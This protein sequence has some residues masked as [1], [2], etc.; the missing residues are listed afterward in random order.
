MPA[1]LAFKW[2]NL[3]FLGDYSLLGI[4]FTNP[5]ISQKSWLS[6]NSLVLLIFFLWLSV[7]AMVNVSFDDLQLI[8]DDEK[9]FAAVLGCVRCAAPTVDV[10]P[11][12]VVLVEDIPVETNVDSPHLIQVELHWGKK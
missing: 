9:G 7:M 6:T 11:K 3:F 12:L 5:H 10:V 2:K 4:R 8:G 1:S